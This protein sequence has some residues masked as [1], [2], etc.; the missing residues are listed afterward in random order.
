[1]GVFHKG[2]VF[3]FFSGDGVND[4]IGLMYLGP[5]VVSIWAVFMPQKSY[6]DK[7]W[8]A[9]CCERFGTLGGEG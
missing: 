9:R 5:M 6:C 3:H 8:G 2:H 1:M 7:L 4:C